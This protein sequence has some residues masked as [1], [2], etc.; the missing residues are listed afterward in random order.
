MAPDLQTRPAPEAADHPDRSTAMIRVGRAARPHWPWVLLT[1]VTTALVLVP[2]IPLQWQA[3]SDGADGMRRLVGMSDL[4]NV[5]VNTLTLGIGALVVGMVLGTVLALASYSMR[6]RLRKKLEFLPVL[7]MVVPSVA[8]VVGFVFLFSP[9]NGY[10]NTLLRATPFFDGASGPINVYTFEWIIAYTGTHLAAFVY[11][12]VYTGLRNL[13]SDYALAARVNG[14]GPVRALFTIT[15]PLLRPTLVYSSVVVFLLALGQF[16]GPLLLGRREGLDVVTTKMYTLSAEYPVDYQLAS[17]LGTPLLLLAI[18]LV[19]FQTRS[20]ANQNRFVGQGA[21]SLDNRQLTRTGSAVSACIVLAYTTIAAFLPLL[22]IAFVGLSPYWSGTPSFG[23]MT[24]EHF[25]A[26]LNDPQILQAVTT[27][28]TVSL[29]GVA[30]VIPLGMLISLAIYNRDRMWRPVPAVLDL[31]ANMP[32]TVP[33][34]LLG[35]GF[36]FAFS[37]PGIGLYGSQTSLIIAYVTIMLP[38]SVRY[39]L[40]TIMSLGRSTLEASQVSGAHPLRTFFQVLLP[41][42]RAGIASSAAIVFVLLTHEF[43]VSLL[44]RG[45]TTKVLSVVLFDEYGGGTYAQVAVIALL[46]TVVTGLGVALAMAFGGRR[47][48]ERL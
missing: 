40:A 26:V 45:P 24:T 28:L 3:W 8:H 22:A 20:L 43:G 29:T 13:G 16:T 4:Q 46:M 21:S 27:T 2:V 44:L 14:A 10:A 12:F 47:A 37:H 23:A 9:E 7:P 31:V 15:L 25:S 30:I 33:A 17:A 35:F 1:V 36:L 32:L 34:A 42:A 11:L 18:F 39:Q 48:L 41:L 38:Y 6:P 5:A 19:I